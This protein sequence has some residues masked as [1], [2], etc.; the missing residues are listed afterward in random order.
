VT[1]MTDHESHIRG[2]ALGA[3]DFL[4]KPISPDV[5]R[6]R[7]LNALEREQLRRESELYQRRLRDSLEQLAQHS[8]ML[9]AIFDHPEEAYLVLDEQLAI[10]KVNQLGQDWL[11]QAF[12]ARDVRHLDDLQLSTLEGRAI[13]AQDFPRGPTTVRGMTGASRLPDSYSGKIN[14]V[15]AVDLPRRAGCWLQKLR[16]LAR[17]RLVGNWLFMI[18]MPSEGL[19]GNMRGKP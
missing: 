6:V 13:C 15:Y 16:H 8:S 19:H 12:G 4:H 14:R 7:V 5:L 1:A 17:R 18:N 11:R 10:V 2:L 9:E 3:L